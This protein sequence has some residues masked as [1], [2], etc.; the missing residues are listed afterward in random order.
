MPAPVPAPT[1]AGVPFLDNV[2]M[3]VWQASGPSA[4]QVTQGQIHR[5]GF[6]PHL[7][8]AAFGA[9][10]DS[11][12]LLNEWVNLW[13]TPSARKRMWASLRQKLYKDRRKARVIMVSDE[14]YAALSDIAKRHQMT[15]SDAILLLTAEFC[16]RLN[17]SR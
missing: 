8:I 5:A 13:L 14:A 16:K 12:A 4:D 11:P 3:S 17:Y 6:W 9:V 7:A 15:F 1:G 2:S 10:N